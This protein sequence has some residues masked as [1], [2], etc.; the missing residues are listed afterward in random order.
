[1]FMLVRRLNKR[2]KDAPIFKLAKDQQPR[3]SL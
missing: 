1:M 3:N 2:D